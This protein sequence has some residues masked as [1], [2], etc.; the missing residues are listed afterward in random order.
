M[1]S[2][3]PHPTHLGTESLQK[4]QE[5]SPHSPAKRPLGPSSLGAGSAK[6]TVPFPSLYS[7]RWDPSPFI[8]LLKAVFKVISIIPPRPPPFG[9]RGSIM[10]ESDRIIKRLTA[11]HQ[12]AT[13]LPMLDVSNTRLAGN[14]GNQKENTH[15]FEGWADISGGWRLEALLNWETTKQRAQRRNSTVLYS[16]AAQGCPALTVTGFQRETGTCR[17]LHYSL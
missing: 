1:S 15:K 13:P 12:E 14:Q 17:W 10:G 2:H 4:H 7:L 6:Q 16:H 9:S 5:N 11:R 3:H 8:L